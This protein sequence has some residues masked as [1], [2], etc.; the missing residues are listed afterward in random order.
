MCCFLGEIL[1]NLYL[2]KKSTKGSA[3]RFQPAVHSIVCYQ[4]IDISKTTPL[5]HFIINLREWFSL[6]RTRFQLI[7][8]YDRLLSCLSVVMSNSVFY[9]KGEPWLQKPFNNP[10]K[11]SINFDCI[12]SIEPLPLVLGILIFHIRS[13][14]SAAFCTGFQCH[15]YHDLK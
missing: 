3:K 6:N 12:W 14:D 5:Q 15:P 7:L 11:I 1:L 8:T 13:S 2:E 4:L 10:L 9:L